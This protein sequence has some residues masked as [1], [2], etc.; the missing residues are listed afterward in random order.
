MRDQQGERGD[1]HRR[2]Q[3]VQVR[4][5]PPEQHQPRAPGCRTPTPGRTPTRGR[6]PARAGRPSRSAGRPP[7]PQRTPRPPGP[8]GSAPA[9][10]AGSP[11]T[12]AR[13]SG[14][15]L[16]EL[17]APGQPVQHLVEGARPA[18]TRRP[19]TR[20]P[21]GRRAPARARSCASARRATRARD[22]CPRA[23]PARRRPGACRSPGSGGRG[24]RCRRRPW[25]SPRSASASAAPR[26]CPRWRAAAPARWWPASGAPRCPTGWPTAARSSRRRCTHPEPKRT[27]RPLPPTTRSATRSP[28]RTAFS[29]SAAAARTVRSRLLAEPSTPPER[30]WSATASITS[31]MPAS[32]SA[33]V[34]V[35]CSRLVRLETRQLI[36]RS[37][38]PGWNS[39][40][41]ANSEPDPARADRCAP[42]RPRGCGVSAREVYAVG[43]GQ[44]LHLQAGQG[45]RPPAVARP[46]GRERHPLVAQHPPAPAAR[47][48]L[49]DG[50]PVAH[51]SRDPSLGRMGGDVRRLGDRPG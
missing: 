18:A 47:A 8:A 35:A 2:R 31:R 10:P 16:R 15:H 17:S 34:V 6:A 50:E 43:A 29:A 45:D 19:D 37:R 36:R 23:A 4:P 9:R 48:D 41:P 39:R 44:H 33:R 27:C 24:A 5:H 28:R 12:P 40:I 13:S 22:R 32:S 51:Q 3:I 7:R 30:P 46:P 49:Q 42:T 20:G 25:R 14:P 21:T 26:W 11:T 38:S 1:Q